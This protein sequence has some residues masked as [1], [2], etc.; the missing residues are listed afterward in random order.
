MKIIEDYKNVHC[1]IEKLERSQ[2]LSEIE[3]KSVLVL[4]Q[5]I[6]GHSL[7]SK[8]ELEQLEDNIKSREQTNINKHPDKW[9]EIANKISEF[10]KKYC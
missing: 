2:H 5:D 8:A 3:A 4:L 7:P 10:E 6:V 1:A 9:F